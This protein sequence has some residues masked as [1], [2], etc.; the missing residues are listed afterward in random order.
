MRILCA[1][2]PFDGHFLPLTGIAHHL[3]LSGH[4]VRFYTGPSYA[5]RLAGLELPHLPFRRATEVNGEN[6]AEHFPEIEKLKGP[7]RIAFDLEKIFFGNTKSH[8]DDIRDIRAEFSFDALIAD[9]AFY[10]AYLVA[11]KLGRPRLRSRTGAD[12]RADVAHRATAVLRAHTRDEPVHAIE[13]PRRPGH[14][15]EH[16]EAGHAAFNE[17]LVSEGLPRYERSVF[18]LPWDAATRFFQTGVP[19]MDFPREDWP[20][21]HQFVGPLLP[22][23]TSAPGRASLRRK[24]RGSSNPSSWSRRAPWTT[25]TPRSSSSRRSP[26]LR[27]ANTSRSPAPAGR[28]TD[29]L[30]DRFPHDN[31]LVE[32]WVDF[33][34]LLPRADLFICNGG[35]GSIM[36]ALITDVPILSA[37]KLEA[38]NDINAR[39]AYRGLGLDLKTERP[40]AGQI[41]AER[42][43][44]ARR[45]VVQDERRTRRCGAERETSVRDDRD[46]AP[47]RLE[48][49][50]H[51]RSPPRLDEHDHAVARV[52]R[53]GLV[54]EQHVAVAITAPMTEP[55]AGRSVKGLSTSSESARTVTSSTSKRSLFEHRDL[56]D[57]RVVGEAHHLLGRHLARVDRD[58]DAA[59]LVDL[60]RHL[61]V[62]ERDR[63]AHA[64]ALGEDRAVEV[65]RVVVEREDRGGRRGRSARARGTPGRR[66]GRGTRA[67]PAGARRCRARARAGRRRS[68]RG[69]HARAARRR[70]SCPSA[71][72]RRS[73]RRRRAPPC[74]RGARPGTRGVR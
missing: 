28:H 35:Y 21:N 54:R 41:S 33:D 1:S 10:A 8:F 59:G 46:G 53:V 15:R 18:D 48:R 64:V 5:K 11:K 69:C 68:G 16:D 74:A 20:A 51:Q 50:L 42:E 36:Q 58:V 29:A 71:R 65:A 3:R 26:R 49:L 34:A 45:P 40:N 17:L 56:A 44:R 63:H 73:R 12:A 23:R 30:R 61:V 57:A 43:A 67:R 70:S 37:G 6:I 52:Q 62:R 38:K 25:G 9:G 2:M 7:R 55:V 39:L 14:G 4:D 22:P 31:V 13:A 47:R 27:A 32:D 66:L 19:E 24:A 60:D 72:R